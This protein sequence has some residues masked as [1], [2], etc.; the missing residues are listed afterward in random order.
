MAD[1]RKACISGIQAWSHPITHS[2]K[3]D[4]FR[5]PPSHELPR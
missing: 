4:R 1:A 2:K 3:A 5:G